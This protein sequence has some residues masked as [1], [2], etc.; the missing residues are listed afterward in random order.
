MDNGDGTRT[1]IVL[2]TGNATLYDGSG[3]AI[4]RNP[5]QV[6]FEFLVDH[7][8]T[9]GDPSDDVGISEAL[10]KGSTGRTDDFCEALVPALT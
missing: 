4:G 9:P 5:G 10:I 8:G 2:S 6:R 1:V 3:K 7:N